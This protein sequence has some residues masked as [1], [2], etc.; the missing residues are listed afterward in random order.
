MLGSNVTAFYSYLSTNL[1]RS[2]DN[3]KHECVGWDINPNHSYLISQTRIFNAQMLVVE[4]HLAEGSGGGSTVGAGGV[5]ECF[6]IASILSSKLF[7]FGFQNGI[8]MS[9][10]LS[11]LALKEKTKVR[12]VIQTRL[13]MILFTLSINSDSLLWAQKAPTMELV[14]LS[15]KSIIIA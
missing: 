6:S 13:S 2:C 1:G 12:F 4:G 7:I 15:C 5:C 10:L 11:L 14:F 9:F 3:L 8:F